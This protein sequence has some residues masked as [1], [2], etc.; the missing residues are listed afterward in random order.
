MTQILL[1]VKSPR[2]GATGRVRIKVP[3]SYA[4]DGWGKDPEAALNTLRYA[5]A[6]AARWDGSDDELL[7]TWTALRVEG[8]T[9]VCTRPHTLLPITLVLTAQIM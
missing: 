5:F 1:S 7:A 4:A 6:R 9:L 3:E 8:P 2:A